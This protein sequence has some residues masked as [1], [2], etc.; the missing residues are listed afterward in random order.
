[1]LDFVCDKEAQMQMQQVHLWGGNL[2]WAVLL[3]P[4]WYGSGV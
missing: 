4:M 1:M 2:V 3:P